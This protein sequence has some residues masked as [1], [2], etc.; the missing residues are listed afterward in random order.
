MTQDLQSRGKKLDHLL[1][2]AWQFTPQGQVLDVREYGSGNVNDTFLVTLDAPGEARFILQRLNTGVFRQPELVMGNLR[3]MTEH[4]RWRLQRQPLGPGRRFEVPRVLLAQG[5]RSSLQQAT[6]VL[7]E[8]R[9]LA[10]DMHNTRRAIEILGLLALVHQA[11]GA[12]TEALDALEDAVSNTVYDKSIMVA[13]YIF[14]CPCLPVILKKLRN[15]REAVTFQT[16]FFESWLNHVPWPEIS[17]PRD[18]KHIAV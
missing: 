1:A 7:Q 9:Q 5:T 12:P 4:V 6:S 16:R 14:H 15:L 11:R 3:T 13:G 18:P 17:P 10:D 8:L 2:L